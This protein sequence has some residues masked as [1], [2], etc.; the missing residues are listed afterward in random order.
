MAKALQQFV[1]SKRINRDEGNEFPLIIGNQKF[2]VRGDLLGSY[3]IVSTKS[4]KILST[5]S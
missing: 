5:L 1:E 3:A 2:Y 4:K